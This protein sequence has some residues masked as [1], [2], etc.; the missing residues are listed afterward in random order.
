MKR[1]TRGEAIKK[2][3]YECCGENHAEVTRCPAKNC[4]LWI[5]RKGKEEIISEN[6]A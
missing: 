1:L 3:C 5:F 6:E 2:F 4:P